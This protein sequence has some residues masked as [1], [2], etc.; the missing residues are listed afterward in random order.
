[1]IRLLFLIILLAGSVIVG[2]ALNHDPGEVLIST[3]RWRVEAPL[4]ISVL[5]L[6]STC[7]IL[8]FLFSLLR[9]LFTIPSSLKEWYRRHQQFRAQAMTREGLIEFSEGYWKSAQAHLI[10]ALPN[11]DIPL[12]NYLTAARAAQELGQ[13][14]LRDHY[15]RLA[16][17]IEPNANIA[18]KLTQAQLQI[19]SQ[20]WEQALATL[21]HL[22]ELA[23][24]HP[25]VLK[26]LIQLY[27]TVKDWAALLRLLPSLK[28]YG[29]QS[30]QQLESLHRRFSLGFFLEQCKHPN[31]LEGIDAA[32]K[33][34]PKTYQQDI[35]FLIPYCENLT[36]RQEWQL[37]NQLIKQ[38]LT[39]TINDSLLLLYTE[40]PVEDDKLTFVKKLLKSY[41]HSANLHYC[42]GRFSLNTHLFGQAKL[43]FE[44]ALIIDPK[45]HLYFYLGA[46]LEKLG[47][48]QEA[49]ASYKQGLTKIL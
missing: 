19:T 26:L 13:L 43:H 37:A 36:E 17:Q 15:L 49:A 41:P 40:L 18:V 4:W 44:Q 5:L 45:P 23:P 8:Y 3:Q 12:F 14:Q 2:I 33:K 31:H 38:S 11:T 32:F 42:L 21:Q 24:K 47:A 7:F 29:A 16:Q 22:H 20:Q 28:K 48:H 46:T 34:L 6:I 1:M 39:H 9:C 27:E 10:K 25:Y 30:S 35:D